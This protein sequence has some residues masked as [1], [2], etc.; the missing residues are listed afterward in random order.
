MAWGVKIESE[1]TTGSIKLS[2]KDTGDG[3]DAA[4]AREESL[5]YTPAV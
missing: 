3:D 4:E 2:V 1:R 5:Q